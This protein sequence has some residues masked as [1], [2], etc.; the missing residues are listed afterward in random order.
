M[1]ISRRDTIL[2]T[3]L[4]NL[5]VVGILLVT[6]I[7][8][9][10]EESPR[11]STPR[12]QELVPLANNSDRENFTKPIEVEKTQKPLDEV[13]KVIAAYAAENQTTK[14]EEI[15]ETIKETPPTAVEKPSLKG[16]YVT[17]TVKRG[18]SLDKLARANGTTIDEIKRINHL[19]TDRLKVGQSL[20]IP[21]SSEPS[22]VTASPPS[23]NE[24]GIYATVEKGDNPWKI[25]RR[26]NVSYTQIL[27]LNDLDENSARNLKVGDKIRVK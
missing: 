16:R 27:R 11:T 23:S 21:I 13:D 12:V 6:A 22:V 7:T 9:Q 14:I 8:D 4:I 1:T 20:Q 25:A 10:D 17:V 19:M 5:G 26:Y 2:M 24:E 18:D 15:K 3:V